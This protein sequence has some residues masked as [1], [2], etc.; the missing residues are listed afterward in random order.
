MWEMLYPQFHFGVSRKSVSTSATNTEN[1]DAVSGA[2]PKLAWRWKASPPTH[3]QFWL[4]EG[5]VQGEANGS[6]VFSRLQKQFFEYLFQPIPI[7]FLSLNSSR[8]FQGYARNGE[9]FSKPNSHHTSR[10]CEFF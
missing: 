8:A 4:L 5:E 7:Y 3:G 6:A 10:I 1:S 2:S 9:K